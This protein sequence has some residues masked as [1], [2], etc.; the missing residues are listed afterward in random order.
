MQNIV[1]IDQQKDFELSGKSRY[2]VQIAAQLVQKEKAAP[3][4]QRLQ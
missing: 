2:W 1:R 3:K 4:P